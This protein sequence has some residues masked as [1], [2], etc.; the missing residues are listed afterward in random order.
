MTRGAQS[1]NWV[2]LA[3]LYENLPTLLGFFMY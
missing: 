3:A 2:P 1:A